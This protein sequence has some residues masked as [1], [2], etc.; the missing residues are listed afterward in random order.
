[1]PTLISYVECQDPN[2]DCVNTAQA[3]REVL[4]SIWCGEGVIPGVG[5]G[6]SV[7]N[8]TTGLCVNVNPGNAVIQGDSVPFQGLYHVTHTAA[9]PVCVTTGS[10]PAN[11]RIDRLVLRIYDDTYDGSGQCKAQLEILTG[12]P[13]AAPAAPDI[14]ASAISL[15]TMR[16]EAGATTYGTVTVNIPQAKQCQAGMPTG[17]VTPFAGGTVPDDWLLCDGTAY[18]RTTYAE[19]FAAIGTT[20]GAG[21]GSSTFNV[22]DMRGRFPLGAGTGIDGTARGAGW[23]GGQMTLSVANLPNHSHS[24]AH[25]HANATTTSDAHTHTFSLRSATGSAAGAAVGNQSVFGNGTTSSDAHSHS[26]NIPSYSGNTSGTGSGT[27]FLP[28]ALGLNYI[29]KA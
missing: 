5:A 28:P 15:A 9:E 12:V 8:L 17:A 26:V 24:M 27:A 20:Y 4:S 23:K 25:D 7:S 2:G 1:M 10:D 6:M 3:D 13:A 19:L 11:P 21:N 16:A 14:P 18:S 29:I 22:P